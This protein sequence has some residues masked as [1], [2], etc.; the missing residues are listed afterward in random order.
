MLSLTSFSFTIQEQ[1]VLVFMIMVLG[2][3]PRYRW[4]E[5]RNGS[6]T[7]CGAMMTLVSKISWT[8]VIMEVPHLQRP[9][10]WPLG[11]AFFSSILGSP[12]TKVVD[13]SIHHHHGA[14]QKKPS[15]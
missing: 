14:M 8:N 5:S 3:V 10:P 9:S 4:K 12:F 2:T 1:S 13:S 15:Q 7:N 11:V 6:K